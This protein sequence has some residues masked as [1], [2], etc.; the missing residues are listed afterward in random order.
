MN[1]EYPYGWSNDWTQPIKEEKEEK[2]MKKKYEFETIEC[3]HVWDAP[4]IGYGVNGTAACWDCVKCG[5]QYAAEVNSPEYEDI[6]VEVCDF[7]GLPR[8]GEDYPAYCEC[9]VY[10][11]GDKLE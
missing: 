8:E 1:K 9:I 4:Y 3:D 7:C 10:E 6:Y 5:H 11:E 2:K